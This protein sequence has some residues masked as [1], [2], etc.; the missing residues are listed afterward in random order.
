ME[1]D[2]DV[3]LLMDPWAMFNMPFVVAVVDVI[4]LVIVIVTTVVFVFFRVL[5]TYR[6]AVRSLRIETLS[7][8]RSLSLSLSLY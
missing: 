4:V 1:P 5:N 7:L 8:S 3:D 2:V 6:T